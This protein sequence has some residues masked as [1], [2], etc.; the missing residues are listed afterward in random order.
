LDT[1]TAIHLDHHASTPLD[2]AALEAM[3]PWLLD[4]ANPSSI[5][6]AGRAARK[7]V[8][9]AREEIAGLLG[10]SPPEIVFTSGGTESDN[11]GVRGGARARRAADPGR[12]RV[13]I[14]S[15]EHSATHEAAHG[16]AHEGFEVDVLPVDA[17]GLPAAGAAD[18]ITPS[19]ALLSLILANNET[20]AIDDQLPALARAAHAAGALVHTDAVQAVG[21]IPVDPRALGV[22]LLSFTA[23]KFGGPKG[24]GV[25]W[26]RTGV[27]L[28]AL[29]SGGGQERGRRPGTENVAAIVGLATALRAALARREA[30]AGRLGALR[31]RFENELSSRIPGVRFNATRSPA[32]RRLPTVS[33]VIFPEATAETLLMSLD[34]EGVAASS[35][36]ACAAGTTKPSRVLLACGLAR[37]D[38]LATVRFSF[39]RTTTEAEVERV[40]ELLPRLAARARLVEP[41][42]PAG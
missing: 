19:L 13:A 37:A 39:G 2:P 34:L 38:V 5:H 21:K 6:A 3:L 29:V 40:L 31:D 27:T 33:S 11:L 12:R 14:S 25:L 36:S 30:E 9:D 26:V 15:V 28:E 42:R 22:D 35:G 17:D 24:A 32:T 4:G 1:H 16:L 18:R 10:A 41:L 7:A 20:G 8:E 23:H